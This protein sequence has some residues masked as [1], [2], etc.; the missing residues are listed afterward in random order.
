VKRER[1]ELERFEV[2]DAEKFP[3]HLEFRFTPA[4]GLSEQ[5][6]ELRVRA[7]AEGP[8]DGSRKQI[9]LHV[10]VVGWERLQETIAEDFRDV[11]SDS[12]INESVQV[13]EFK[14]LP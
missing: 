9:A 12:L 11:I 13:G 6:A 8:P 7:R 2:R 1:G 14:V 3:A 10:R 5:T 4:S